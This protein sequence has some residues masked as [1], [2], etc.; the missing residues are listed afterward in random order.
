MTHV[1]LLGDSIFDNGAYTSGGPDIVTQ[2]R[3]L[4]PASWTATLLAVDGARVDDVTRQVERLPSEASHLVLSVGGN[5]ALA[6]SE[7]L[8]GPAAS[9]PQLLGFLAD[10]AESFERRYRRL[11]HRLLERE[12]PLTVCTIYN[13]N[14]PDPGFQ[15]LVSTAL[16]IFNDPILRIACER[17]LIVIDLRLVCNEAADYANPIEPSSTGGGKIAGAILR[18]L[19]GSEV[20]SAS[21]L[22]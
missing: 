9:A 20:G 18:A 17:R 6:H 21:V 8:E 2:L 5:D 12:L 1:V 10:A 11:V 4:V 22:G 15:R 19:Q 3:S 7:L 13:G 16:C 14:F